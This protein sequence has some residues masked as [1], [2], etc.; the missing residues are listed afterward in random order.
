VGIAFKHIWKGKASIWPLAVY[1][2]LHVPFSLS[3]VCVCVCVCRVCVCVCG[4]VVSIVL[5]VLTLL[6]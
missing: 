4:G 6:L 5:H 2:V 1:A 3:C